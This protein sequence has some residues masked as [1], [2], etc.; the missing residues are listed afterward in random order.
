MLFLQDQIALAVIFGN[1]DVAQGEP[2]GFIDDFFKVYGYACFY[3]SDTRKI[4][5]IKADEVTITFVCLRYPRELC[6][7][8]EHTLHRKITS[9]GEGIY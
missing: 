3:K 8:L 4:N 9:A 1:K 7:Y 5:E 2:F 6:N